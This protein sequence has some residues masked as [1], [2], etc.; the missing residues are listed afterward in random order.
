MQLVSGGCL[1]NRLEE[2]SQVLVA[3]RPHAVAPVMSEHPGSTHL[4]LRPPPG[5][6]VRRSNRLMRW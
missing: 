1:P 5:A 2:K 3:P 6:S 4:A